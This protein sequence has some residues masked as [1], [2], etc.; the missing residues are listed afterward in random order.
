MPTRS[1]QSSYREEYNVPNSP[2]TPFSLFEQTESDIAVYA[3]T[4]L[5]IPEETI[6]IVNSIEN[7][8]EKRL[9]ELKKESGFE[10]ALHTFSKRLDTIKRASRRAL[11][12]VLIVST[13]IG[14]A[15]ALFQSFAAERESD[16]HIETVDVS[17]EEVPKDTTL[18]IRDGHSTQ[19]EPE[20]E[21]SEQSYTETIGDLTLYEEKL[22]A[23]RHS[24]DNSPRE[25]ILMVITQE[26]GTRIFREKE[27]SSTAGGCFPTLTQEDIQK[28]IH[29]EQ[30]H[31]H[32]LGLTIEVE[33]GGETVRIVSHVQCM[34]PSMV[35][36]GGSIETIASM[37]TP[38]KHISFRVIDARGD[39]VYTVEPN[40]P[41]LKKIENYKEIFR[42]QAE[43]EGLVLTEEEQQAVKEHGLTL[44]TI[45]ETNARG[46]VSGR[47]T[48]PVLDKAREKITAQDAL[49]SKLTEQLIPEETQLWLTIES[50]SI[51][52]A[53][54]DR[55]EG[56]FMRTP[57]DR[58]QYEKE[59]AVRITRLCELYKSMGITMTYTL[60]E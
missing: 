24:A 2:E 9:A 60:H 39:W 13:L 33:Q 4:A 31:T 20:K 17:H 7:I 51:E 10:E 30:I 14:P 26:N 58:A 36:I 22:A 3:D 50:L 6:R 46:I 53:S 47:Y 35:D 49:H 28:S 32:P 23:L 19:E 29:I 12:R 45:S 40:H 54:Y 1:E 8:P 48:D 18:E 37:S 15:S 16:N 52:I 38:E 55:E 43:E 56:V 57:E 34:A 25:Q 59:H 27:L 41:F 11:E 21:I 5:S 44:N 42:L